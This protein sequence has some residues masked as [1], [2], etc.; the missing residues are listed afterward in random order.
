LNEE[1]DRMETGL[2]VLLGATVARALLASAFALV[3]ER[4]GVSIPGELR[5]TTPMR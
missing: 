4:N 2:L 1:A 5:S 3:N